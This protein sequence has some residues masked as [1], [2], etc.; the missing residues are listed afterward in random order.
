[1]SSVPVPQHQLYLDQCHEV[2]GYILHV[3]VF[4]IL[5]QV[6][7]CCS[8]TESNLNISIN[9][10]WNSNQQSVLFSDLLCLSTR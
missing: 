2:C 7:S 4:I 8:D 3:A 10:S 1:V 6:D 5:L 9:K